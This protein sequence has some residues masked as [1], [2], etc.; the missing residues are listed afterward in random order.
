MG[1]QVLNFCFLP[2]LATFQGDRSLWSSSRLS[3][4]GP[5]NYNPWLS[6]HHRPLPPSSLYLVAFSLSVPR[7]NT[8]GGT[9]LCLSQRPAHDLGLVWCRS[10][11]LVFLS[12]LSPEADLHFQASHY[13]V[14]IIHSR[15]IISPTASQRTQRPARPSAYCSAEGQASFSSCVLTPIPAS[16]QWPFPWLFPSLLGL[17]QTPL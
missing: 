2:S 12:L 10:S 8:Y 17:R 16:S 14:A 13:S 6:L 3:P 11:V 15:Q 9:H 4:A 5:A 7:L 1:S